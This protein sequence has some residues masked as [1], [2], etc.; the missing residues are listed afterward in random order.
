MEVHNYQAIILD[1]S[2]LL[3]IL[4]GLYNP[5]KLDKVGITENQFGHLISYIQQFSERLITPH[6]LAE[7]SNLAKKR[8]KDDF[9]EFMKF[10]V[11]FLRDLN[12]QQ[13]EKEDIIQSDNIKQVIDFGITDTAI[14]LASTT[15][16]LIITADSPFFQ[17]CY[18]NKIPV[19][20]TEAIFSKT[21]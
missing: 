10:I 8:L 19:L 13:I 9:P 1:T 2:P 14:S 15:K 6:I 21:V 3:Q 11:K 7:M 20:H 17:Y 4:V 18:N 5:K 16:R 12:E